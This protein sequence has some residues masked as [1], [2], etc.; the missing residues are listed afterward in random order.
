MAA[1]TALA[2]LRTLLGAAA[3]DVARVDAALHDAKARTGATNPPA[4][5]HAMRGV[6]E[7]G[8]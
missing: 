1:T 7:E 8:E 2:T 5:F 6:E 4:S 3:P